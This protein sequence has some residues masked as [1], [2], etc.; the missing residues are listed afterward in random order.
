M[1][2]RTHGRL[3]AECDGKE[4]A[5]GRARFYSSALRASFLF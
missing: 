4:G 2:G 3:V 1:R 5:L